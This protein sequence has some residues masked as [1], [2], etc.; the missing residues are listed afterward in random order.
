ME[1]PVRSIKTDTNRVVIIS[2]ILL[3]IGALCILYIGNTVGTI[4]IVMYCISAAAA[5]I[6]T[7][8]Q[9][10]NTTKTR[11]L[12]GLYMDQTGEQKMSMERYDEF[13]KTYEKRFST[14]IFWISCLVVVLWPVIFM[15]AGIEILAYIA[16]G[17]SL[18]GEIG[19]YKMYKCIKN[20]NAAWGAGMYVNEVL[21]FLEKKEEQK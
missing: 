2:L 17:L 19:K 4:A 1:T 10:F 16:I 12:V 11:M 14:L 15:A 9:I 8:L 20:N 7:L 13:I 6:G 21:N 3:S 5:A 18:A